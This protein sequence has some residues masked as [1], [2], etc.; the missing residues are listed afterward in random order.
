MNDPELT[1]VTQLTAAV[2]RL[3]QKYEKYINMDL[4]RIKG[5]PG[6]EGP[7]GDPGPV[8]PTGL[9]GETGPQGLQGETGPAGP[10]GIPGPVGPVGPQ[11]AGLTKGMILMWSGLITEIPEGWA[12]C[13]GQE[14]RPNLLGKFVMGVSSATT[15]PGGTGG[16]NQRT[17]SVSNLPAHSHTGTLSS[18][19]LSLSGEL[20]EN[21]YHLHEVFA[22][23]QSTTNRMLTIG[24][25]SSAPTIRVTPQ[26]SGS[27]YVLGASA[28]VFGVTAFTDRLIGGASGA[29]KHDLSAVRATLPNTSLSISSTGGDNAFDNRPAYYELAY[30][31]KL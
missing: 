26:T 3:V 20:A 30:I 13:D 24:N 11:V 28:A 22:A 25:V 12:L 9:K 16:S 17:L 7:R 14:G 18:Q 4:L 21:G 6:P 1:G 10:Q 27:H 29:H 5:D 15:N 31:V 2:A 23:F 19:Q 8:G